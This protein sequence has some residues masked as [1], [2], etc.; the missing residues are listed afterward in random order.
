MTGRAQ[1]L[2]SG[3][4]A[5]AAVPAQ[6]EP[7]P[8]GWTLVWSD[9][10]DGDR[11]DPAK[12]SHDVDCWGGGNAERQCYTDRPA[13]SRVSGGLLLIEAHAGETRG[14][15]LP[16]H[17]RTTPE[18]AARTVTLPF[19][20]AR[21]TTRGKAEWRYGRIEVRARLPGGQGSWPAIWMLPTVDHY[22]G[23][24][25][26]GEIDIMEA[27]NL[28]VPCETCPL[29]R[30]NRVLGTLHFGGAWPAN[31]HKG[32]ETELP[33]SSD[34][35]HVFGILWQPGRIDWTID[36]KVHA[37]QTPADWQTGVSAP[38]AG[39]DAPFDRPFHLIL[40]LAIGGGLPEGRNAGGVDRK[41]FPRRME[42]DWVRVWQASEP[43]TAR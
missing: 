15:A 24:A 4:L 42:V 37:S 8:A 3:L 5:L 25:G 23:W 7:A 29:K 6:A 19:S 41:G 43:E 1:A 10:F 18:D 36:G 38:D 22:G 34:G 11:L 17:L 40:N 39:P 21:L 35:F 26:S 32:S 9:E 12:W 27:V 30:E 31:V 13:N 14:P 16:V 2:A 20:S 33:P 28:G